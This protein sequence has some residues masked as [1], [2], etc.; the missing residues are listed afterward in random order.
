MDVR[1]DDCT[2]RPGRALQYM[3]DRAP[4]KGP[5]THLTG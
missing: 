1:T 2:V 3:A 5:K 4:D